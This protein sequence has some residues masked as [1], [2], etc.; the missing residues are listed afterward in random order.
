MDEIGWFLAG[1][2]EEWQV[3]VLPSLKESWYPQ[4]SPWLLPSTPVTPFLCCDQE[5]SHNIITYSWPDMKSYISISLDIWN[6]LIY[7][8]YGSN[9]QAGF[10]R[11]AV[12]CA[13]WTQD[14]SSFKYKWH[15]CCTSRHFV[16]LCVYSFLVIMAFL[17]MWSSKIW[18]VLLHIEL[19][20]I[21]FWLLKKLI[22]VEL[23]KVFH[24]S[25]EQFSSTARKP[26]NWDSNLWW[27]ADIQLGAASLTMN[28]RLTLCTH[29]MFARSFTF[30]CVLYW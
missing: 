9:L 8:F 10:N 18:S 1:A 28:G 20:E 25:H 7:A 16:Y 19:G 5:T 2:E 15:W 23:C 29:T 22:Q 11:N 17:V 6:V 30:K 27:H 24:Y 14:S 3:A 12:I 13:M 4:S 21:N 26:K